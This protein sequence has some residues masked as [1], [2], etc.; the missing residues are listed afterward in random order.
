MIARPSCSGPSRLAGIVDWGDA[1]VGHA[2]LEVTYMAADLRVATGSQDAHWALIDV[3][4]ELRGPLTNRGWWE[5]AGYLR[6]PSDPADW[7]AGWTE[8]GLSLSAAGVRAR[9]AIGLAHARNRL[10]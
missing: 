6:L 5:M 8:A 10:T 7:L 4:E 2:A 9:D 1:G 3:Y